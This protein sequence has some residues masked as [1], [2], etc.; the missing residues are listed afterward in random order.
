LTDELLG[1]HSLA[2]NKTPNNGTLDDALTSIS[3]WRCAIQSSRC[4]RPEL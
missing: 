4:T 2:S 1:L 3:P